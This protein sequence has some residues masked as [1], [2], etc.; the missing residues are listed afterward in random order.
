MSNRARETRERSRSASPLS[1]DVINA[2]AAELRQNPNRNRNGWHVSEAEQRRRESR[3]LKPTMYMYDVA[4]PGLSLC[5]LCEIT[6]NNDL[7]TRFIGHDEIQAE[8]RHL[9]C[10]EHY[11]DNKRHT[12]SKTCPI[13]RTRMEIWVQP[14]IVR[15][16]NDGTETVI[17]AGQRGGKRNHTRGCN[18]RHNR[19]RITR[20]R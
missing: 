17:T 16:A 5:N 4:Q 8:H 6:D 9:L 19:M 1:M 20:R 10:L 13:C 7:K 18:R 12:E 3:K 14:K 11:R 15:I 2:I